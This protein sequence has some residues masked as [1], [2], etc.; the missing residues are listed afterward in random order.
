MP[1]NV[2]NVLIPLKSC[3]NILT[4]ICCFTT[5][6]PLTIKFERKL[7][8]KYKLSVKINNKYISLYKNLC[9]RITVRFTTKVKD[10]LMGKN[11]DYQS[12]HFV[13]ITVVMSPYLINIL[14]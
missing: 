4:I 8:A 6:L 13:G 3:H 12:I 2:T 9:H 10:N 7:P 11:N 14:V 1:V 5:S